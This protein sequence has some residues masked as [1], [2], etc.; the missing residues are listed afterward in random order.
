MEENQKEAPKKFPVFTLIL[1]ILVIGLGG[2]SGYKIFE[3]LNAEK[4]EEKVA[5]RIDGNNYHIV[6]EDGVIYYVIDG[7]Y[8]GEMDLQYIDIRCNIDDT[9]DGDSLSRKKTV[10]KKV[11]NREDFLKSEVMDYETYAEF[12]DTWGLD[13][14]FSDEDVNYSVFS[15]FS[16]GATYIEA[17][18]ANVDYGT[19][20]YVWDDGHGVTADMAG[21]VIIV[22]TELGYVGEPVN[23]IT[24]Y[25]EDDLERIRHPSREPYYSIDKPIVYLYPEEET[26]VS[27]KLGSPDKLTVSYP[28]Y[29][30]SWNV[31]AKP[32]GTLK[33][34]TGREFYGLYYEAKPTTEFS[35]SDTGFVVKKEDAA[36]FLEEKLA[37]LGLN[38]REAEEFIVYWLPQMHKSEYN[39]VRF[40][41]ATEIDENMSLSISPKP[42]TTIRVWM[43]LKG[44]DSPIS[45]QEQKLEKKSRS[46]FTAVEWGGVK[47]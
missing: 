22:P 19:T 40:A 44:L 2:F 34:G 31:V 26:N 32:D 10:Q 27:V 17:R 47:L 8:Q 42:D 20:F 25:T 12:C 36:K 41:S 7:D 38:E 21:Y 39:Y 1:L 24:L 3:D 46:G 23:V 14:K 18:L 6:K 16:M 35:V 37:V 33:D 11:L 4:V 13:K 30:D 29:A 43:V 9:C 5:E 15:Y 28:E 45:V